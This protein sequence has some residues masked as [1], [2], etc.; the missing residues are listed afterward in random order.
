[1]KVKNYLSM[2]NNARE[3]LLKTLEELKREDYLNV[4]KPE[5]EKDAVLIVEEFDKDK[6]FEFVESLRKELLELVESER[7]AIFIKEW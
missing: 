4:L 3:N 2:S 5:V 1:M 6:F 7:F